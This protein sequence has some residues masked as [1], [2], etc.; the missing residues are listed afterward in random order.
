MSIGEQNPSPKHRPWGP[1]ELS[2]IQQFAGQ[3]ADPAY[4]MEVAAQLGRTYESVRNKIRRLTREAST[5]QI[6]PPEN[7][8]KQQRQESLQRIRD[9]ADNPPIDTNLAER[10]RQLE[11]ENARL[12]EQK[13]WETHSESSELVGGLMTL[14]R[15][16]DHHCDEN[17]LLS[18]AAA[19]EAKFIV[20]L[21]RY[22]PDRI[23]LVC[24]DDWIAGRGIFKE[25]DL[26]LA[27][28]DPE[29]Q[30][31]AGAVKFRRFVQ[32]IR[33]VTAAPIDARFL[34]GNH[35]Y[36]GNKTPLGP[37]LF[38]TSRTLCEDIPNLGMTLYHTRALL[39]LA[40]DG[41][42]HVL[43]YHGFGHSNSSPNSPKFIDSAKDHIIQ[44]QRALPP[45][46]HIRRV[47]S[48][49][50]HW[51][52][53]GLERIVDLPF[54]TT[55]GLQ[56]NNRVQLGMNSRPVGWIAYISPRGAV[57]EIQQPI[58]LTPD[59]ETYHRELSDPHLG[60]ANRADCAACL[61]EYDTIMAERKLVVNSDVL[62]VTNGRW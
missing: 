26:Q 1:D 20:L 46:E 39:N 58:T 51:A 8:A 28:S 3:T 10:V 44:V 36:A 13:K 32:A 31:N 41:V 2:V 11:A 30:V 62:G 29:L 43:A 5:A 60:A 57:G 55:G 34:R 12:R 27:V 9:A 22:Q 16:D 35:E 15:S 42:Y 47:L 49:H 59:S 56:R 61:A 24:G 33:K 14:R 4:I 6:T 19:L 18:C 45:G 50:T 54:D 53:T 40:S 21:E 38:L 17:H 7:T 25:Q 23:Q 48:G 52:S 37:A